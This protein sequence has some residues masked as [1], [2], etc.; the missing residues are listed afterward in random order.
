VILTSDLEHLAEFVITGL[1][2]ELGHIT[3]SSFD[4]VMKSQ[5]CSI[6]TG[7]FLPDE[8]TIGLA[9]DLLALV[10]REGL[11]DK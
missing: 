3:G 11:R 2:S 5:V 6:V 10:L 7:L 9:I 8:S 4:F 1:C